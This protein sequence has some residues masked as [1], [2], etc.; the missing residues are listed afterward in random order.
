MIRLV[1]HADGDAPVTSLPAWQDP[2]GFIHSPVLSVADLKSLREEHG[3]SI[4]PLQALAAEARG[5]ER[6]VAELVNAAYGLTAEEMVLMWKAAPP[7]MPGDGPGSPSCP[8][9][10]DG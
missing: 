2:P 3:R 8:S 9:V 6:Q 7:R 1:G 10:V 4:V 5:L